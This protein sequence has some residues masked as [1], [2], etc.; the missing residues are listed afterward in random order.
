MNEAK[1]PIFPL[2]FR[3]QW[4]PVGYTLMALVVAVR[5]LVRFRGGSANRADTSH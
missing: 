1:R 2:S 4:C 5:L 3:R